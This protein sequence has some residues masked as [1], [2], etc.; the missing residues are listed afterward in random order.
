[1]G[2]MAD[3]RDRWS[4]LGED[5]QRQY[6]QQAADL[7]VQ[8]QAGQ[9]SSEMREIRKHLKQ[10]KTE[11]S[12][13]EELG[14]ETAVLL[15]DGFSPQAF[16]QELSS[17]KASD[18]LRSTGT[19]NN[20][21]LFFAGSSKNCPSNSKLDSVKIMVRKVQD[22]FNQKYKEAGG[23]GRLPYKSLAANKI[24]IKVTGLPNDLPFRKPCLYGCNFAAWK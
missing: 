14:V 19:G 22:L 15:H 4:S 20:F 21:G 7:K 1:M 18:F 9:L 6:V 3:I 2:T 5:E 16:V 17:R 12:Q 10:L 13:L 11:V 24:I 23:T 8:G